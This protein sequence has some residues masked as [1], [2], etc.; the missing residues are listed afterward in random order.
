MRQSQISLSLSLSLPQPH[1]PRPSRTHTEKCQAPPA[2]SVLLPLRNT[3]VPP[4]PSLST[5]PLSLFAQTLLLTH[6]HRSC[7]LSCFQSHKITHVSS[8]PSPTSAVALSAPAPLELPTPAVA[9]EPIPKYLRGK[10]DFSRLATDAAFRDMLRSQPTLLPALQ[11]I[12]AATIEPEEGDEP[13]R[14]ARGRG[15]MRG[16]R[17]R[18]RGVGRS[19]GGGGG[20]TPKWTAKK[21][22]KD[23]MRML[24]GLREGKRGETEKEA[25]GAFVR[26][27]GEIFAEGDMGQSR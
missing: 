22:D 21:G 18:G 16:W 24:K 23:A 2:A 14:A 6:I 8:I 1:T 3:N 5:T 9:P 10:A 12:Y 26:L 20:E 25:V 27:V 4:A 13:R 7:S 17:G 19:R 11:R 15:G